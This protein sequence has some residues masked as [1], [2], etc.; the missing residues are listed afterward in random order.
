M[1]VFTGWENTQPLTCF[2]DYV[3]CVFPL[4]PAYIYLYLSQ[5]NI[6]EEKKKHGLP[7]CCRC[8]HAEA[9]V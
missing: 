7:S 6:K 5:T 8:G 3:R 9:R 2:F 1:N 4:L